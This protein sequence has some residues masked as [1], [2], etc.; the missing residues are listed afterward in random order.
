MARSKLDGAADTVKDQLRE[1][2]ERIARL[3][4]KRARDRAR[5]MGDD[6]DAIRELDRFDHLPDSLRDVHAAGNGNRPHPSTY[7]SQEDLDDHV[8]RFEHGGT[9]FMPRSDYDEYGITHRDRTS[10]IMSASE[11]DDMIAQTGGN[12]A[13][14]EQALGL[15]PGTLDGDLVR[16]DVPRPGDHGIRMPTGNE[17]GA[18]PQ[19]LPGGLT[20]SNISEGVIDAGGMVEGT[21]FTVDDFPP[22][23]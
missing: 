6:A 13:L 17:S 11:V 2:F 12:P 22:G 20:P 3:H 21:D 5:K 10:F 8:S 15:T 1:T 14:M 19:W 16:V 18:N 9:R 23:G 7:F 4:R